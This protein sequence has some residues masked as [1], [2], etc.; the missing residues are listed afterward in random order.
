MHI[1]EIPDPILWGILPS[2]EC[3][4]FTL[5]DAPNV[6][7]L[8]GTLRESKLK[9][10]TLNCPYPTTE[11]DL[12]AMADFLKDT[13]LYS[14]VGE[15]YWEPPYDE[16][17]PTWEFVTILGPFANLQALSLDAS[18]GQ[19]CC[20]RFRHEHIVELSKWMP[21]LREL[22]LGGSPCAVGGRMSDIGYYTLAALA[23]NCPN[24]HLLTIHFNIETFEYGG[25]VEPN[26]NVAWWDVGSTSLTTNAQSHTM[27]ALAVANL[28]P[29]ATFMG[30]TA[31]RLDATNWNVIQEELRM[32]TLPA[33]HGWLD[34][35]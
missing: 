18:C 1:P 8:L 16:G 32:L 34:L 5:D 10:F 12:A 9:E 23:K 28:F 15:F 17:P 3:L 21:R 26:W 20:F 13:G 25:F 31:A 30:V 4:T 22:N 27:I 24:L 35:M 7:D 14:S 19:T 2:L 33:D 6:M 11:D 29:K